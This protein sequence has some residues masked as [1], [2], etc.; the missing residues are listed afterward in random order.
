MA[1]LKIIA[2]NVNS[3]VSL[4]KRHIFHHFLLQHKPDLVLISETRLR[5]HHRVFLENYN[6]IR[7]D[8]ETAGGG[9]AIA[10]RNGIIYSECTVSSEHFESTAINVTTDTGTI[11]FES[12]YGISRPDWWSPRPNLFRSLANSNIL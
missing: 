3:L 4:A 7:N 2:I 1:E 12:I 6:F 11:V 8:R 5:K 10:V 9:T